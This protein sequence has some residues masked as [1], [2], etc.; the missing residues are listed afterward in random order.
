MLPLVESVPKC[1][2]L[3]LL[4]GG[5]PFRV[6]VA[7]CCGAPV[8]DRAHEVE[9]L[10]VCA[11]RHLCSFFFCSVD[12][13]ARADLAAEKRKGTFRAVSLIRSSSVCAPWFVK[14]IA[15]AFLYCMFCLASKLF[16]P[17]SVLRG[18]GLTHAHSHA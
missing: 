5:I 1:C 2:M 17:P 15:A 12:S 6:L 13:V 3:L 18:D 8:C 4:C 16:I 10:V 7:C 11:P 9:A 14:S